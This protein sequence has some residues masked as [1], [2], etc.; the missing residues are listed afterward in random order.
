LEFTVFF[1]HALRRTQCPVID[2][3]PHPRFSVGI[4]QTYLSSFQ[5]HPQPQIAGTFT[6]YSV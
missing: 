6:A 4:T 3:R 5:T 2:W 1:L